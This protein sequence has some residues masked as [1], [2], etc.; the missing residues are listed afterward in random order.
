LYADC[1]FVIEAV[2]E[3]VGVK[4]QVFGEIEQI[5]AEDAILATNTSSLS[6]EEIGAELA[7]P[8]RLVGFHFFNPVAVMPLIEIVKTPHTT[9]AALSTAFVVAKSLGKNAVLMADAPGFVVNRLLAKVMGEA[10]RAVYEGTPVVDVEKAFG[11]LGL[12]M[13]PFQLIDLVGFKV[14]AHVQDTMARAFPERFY[15]NENFHALAELPEVV[16]K[17]KGGRVTGFT[18][19]AEKV[20]RPAVGKTPVPADEILR[21]VQDGL[22]QGM[23]IML[24]EGVVPEVEDID[25]CLILGAGWPF[26]DGGA[27][28]YLDREG[29]SERA[30]GD[31][32]HHPPIRGIGGA[33][34]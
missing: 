27:S 29:A 32:F 30:F 11:P 15:A 33:N 5:V 3:E 31:T 9:D 19:A 34:V 13:G 2:F 24:D 12:P 28:P 4:Q 20:L 26:I 25:L 21:R 17:D 14:A 16:E 23:R 10:A 18:K 1:D 6:V 22:A 8:E 7:H